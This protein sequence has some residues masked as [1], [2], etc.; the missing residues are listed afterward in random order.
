MADENREPAANGESPFGDARDEDLA[1][2]R[3]L[4]LPLLPDP[5]LPGQAEF[6]IRGGR[7]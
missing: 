7:G 6:A 1:V 4:L 5:V 2:L 3:D